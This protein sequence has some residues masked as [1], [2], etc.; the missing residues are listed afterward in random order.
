MDRH[1]RSNHR[2]HRESAKDASD[3]CKRESTRPSRADNEYQAFKEGRLIPKQDSIRGNRS[4]EALANQLSGDDD[5][6]RRWLAQTDEE[7]NQKKSGFREARQ[8]SSGQ[9]PFSRY[10]RAERP[11]LTLPFRPFYRP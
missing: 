5:Y 4:Q 7:A 2:E 9:F 1:R 6:V 11:L 8:R 10:H 3:H